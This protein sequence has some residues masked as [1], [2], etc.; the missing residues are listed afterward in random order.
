MNNKTKKRKLVLHIISIA[1]VVCAA[2]AIFLTVFSGTQI[3][4]V[5]NKLVEETLNTA[6]IQMAD[7][8]QRMYEG[9]WNLD[10]DDVLWKGDHQFKGDFIG[11]LKTQTG[12]DYAIF[13]DNVRAV[14][15]VN[16]SPVGRKNAD[17]LAPDD[18]YN[19]VVKS[20]K[21]YYRTNYT[22]ADELYSGVYAPVLDA[23]GSIG[24]MTV[25][26]RKTSDIKKDIRRIVVLM[27]VLA[28]ACVAVF[29]IIGFFLYKSSAHAM[30]NICDGIVKMAD[31]E[32]H[33]EFSSDALNRPDELGTIAQSSKLLRDELNTIVTDIKSQA[34]SVNESSADVSTTANDISHT[35][36]SVAEAVQEIAT[37]ATQQADE[38][39][40]S[41]ESTMIISDNIQKVSTNANELKNVK[42]EIEK[43]LKLNFE[44]LNF[45]LMKNIFEA[46][47]SGFIKKER[48]NKGMKE[49]FEKT[50]EIFEANLIKSMREFAAKYPYA[51]YGARFMYWLTCSKPMPYNSFGNGSA[52]RVSPVAWYFDDIETVEK[53]ARLSAEVT[54]NHPEGI[55]GAQATASAIF[56]ARIGRSKQEIKDY[57][58][59][60]YNYD[61]TRTLDEIRP[62]YYHVESCQQTVPEAITAFLEGESFEDCTRLAVS[63]S[64][65]SDPL[66]AITSSIAEGFYGIP[67]EIC[68]MV[69]PKLDDYLTDLLLRWE[70]WRAR[71]FCGEDRICGLT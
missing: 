1:I 32:L 65:D 27:I 60:K 34:H 49:A 64:G 13:Y 68:E 58:T 44:I 47:F 8:I 35:A 37:G 54:H 59:T 14:T 56:L 19:T 43:L 29:S 17:T 21:T 23:D 24:G 40:D 28:A 36:D 66:T 16:G 63:L 7:E 15:T 30:Q 2:I 26:F 55:K 51:G 33:V 69:M 20:G 9:E 57:I 25:A 61:L 42:T 67:E 4:S 45:S 3:S 22:V 70:L 48:L 18:I 46:S 12:L 62:N 10:E 11:S 39:Q 50:E 31:G 53:F 5:Y 6:A 38:I 52:M 41:T 71:Q